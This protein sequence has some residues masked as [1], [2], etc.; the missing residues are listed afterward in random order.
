LGRAGLLCALAC[1]PSEACPEF[2]ANLPTLSTVETPTGAIAVSSPIL[3]E[4][5]PGDTY[6]TTRGHQKYECGADTPAAA[7]MCAVDLNMMRWDEA[8]GD[9]TASRS[10]ANAHTS[11]ANEDHVMWDKP[12]YAPVDG[13]VIACWRGL[14][15]D[16]DDDDA[17]NCPGGDEQCIPG[18][19]HLTI[20]TADDELVFV[21]HMNQWSIPPE[22]CPIED[23][24]LYASE[25]KECTLGADWV[26]LRT[27][28]R[29]DLRGEAFPSIARGQFIGRVGTSGFGIGAHVHMHAREYGHDGTNPCEGAYLPLAFADLQA[30]RR[31][32]EV[33]PR[34]DAWE[35]VEG[36][37]L[38]I[39]GEP[40]VLW[41]SSEDAPG[42]RCGGS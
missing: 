3:A 22:L 23:V 30:Q 12:L 35:P 18:G 17:V 40:F 9:F 32:V 42:A 4:D 37:V 31:L 29:L 28:A 27:Q 15:D 2:D 6:L 36:E 19:N 11:V 7:R 25:P 41:P 26:G 10:L 16:D 21:A 8:S 39:D 38:P 1:A 20:L 5:L 24:F 14:P 33:E 13:E 34:A